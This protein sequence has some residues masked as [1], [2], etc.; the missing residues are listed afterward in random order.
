[1]GGGRGR[2]VSV[3]VKHI[4]EE[5]TVR[6]LFALH[7]RD[8]M[9]IGNSCKQFHTSSNIE[10]VSSATLSCSN[11]GGIKSAL[12]GAM[13]QKI[14]KRVSNVLAGVSFCSPRNVPPLTPLLS[15]CNPSVL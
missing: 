4:S 1:M 11:Q 13:A 15:S 10:N 2:R 9:E 3:S 12:K 8:G 5:C 7:K 6:S 14:T